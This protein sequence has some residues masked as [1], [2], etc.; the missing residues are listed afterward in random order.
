MVALCVKRDMADLIKQDR[1]IIAFGFVIPLFILMVV[2]QAYEHVSLEKL[3]SE[4]KPEFTQ[5]SITEVESYNSFS[6]FKVNGLLF[7]SEQHS[8][9]CLNIINE[10]ESNRV[11][12]LKYAYVNSWPGSKASANCILEATSLT[13][14][15][16]RSGRSN[17]NT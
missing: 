8:M 6:E 17:L 4:A 3:V 11:V 12:K 10:I 7:R 1:K 16:S 14:K 5:G 13:K 9:P 2:I 15:K